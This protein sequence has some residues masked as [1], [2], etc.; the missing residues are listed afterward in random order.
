MKDTFAARLKYVMLHTHTT[1]ESLALE[2]GY[3]ETYIVNLRKGRKTNPSIEC[4]EC[5][6][7]VLG[8]SPSYLAGWR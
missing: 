4:V 6:A 7:T 3:S 1:V 8:V 2:S 5:L